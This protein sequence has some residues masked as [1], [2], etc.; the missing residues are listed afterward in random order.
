MPIRRADHGGDCCGAEHL[1][2]FPGYAN[3][4]MKAKLRSQ[5]LNARNETGNQRLPLIEVILRD[6]DQMP[7]WGDYLI[8]E[9]GFKK[10]V[11]W[12]N[13]NTNNKLVL[14]V[15]TDRRCKLW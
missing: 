4:Q 8:K 5:L 13:P 2:E 9:V 11:T 12:K 14:L 10:L 3:E 7:I 15:L 6:D 1:Y